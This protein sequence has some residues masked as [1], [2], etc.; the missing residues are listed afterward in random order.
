MYTI[1]CQ[2]VGTIGDS[3]EP[4]EGINIEALLDG[5]F[6]AKKDNKTSSKSAKVNNSQQVPDDLN[7]DTE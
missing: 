5:G 3:F 1:L 7:I 6:I 2:R 4:D